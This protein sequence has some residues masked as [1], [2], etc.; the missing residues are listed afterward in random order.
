MEKVLAKKRA[1]VEAVLADTSETFLSSALVLAQSNSSVLEEEEDVL[2]AV[3]LAY[4]KIRELELDSDKV[5]YDKRRDRV[6]EIYVKYLKFLQDLVDCRLESELPDT[7]KLW[8]IVEEVVKT[9]VVTREDKVYLYNQ[10]KIYREKLL[11]DFRVD[12]LVV[13]AALEATRKIEVLHIEKNIL[14]LSEQEIRVA[15]HQ[16]TPLN[17][18]KLNHV[19]H[20]VRLTARTSKEDMQRLLTPTNA[21]TMTIEEYGDR[22]LAQMK[23]QGLAIP[24]STNPILQE[25]DSESESGDISIEATEAER[26]RKEQDPG[27]VTGDG[28]RMGRK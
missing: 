16:K 2:F 11:N 19:N 26:K 21:P 4:L 22:M 10:K 17:I 5:A 12:W 25:I 6:E 20:P 9:K 27:L 18:Q 14:S 7:A 13:F 8:G 28:N 3:I 15:D 23:Q 1:I 24:S